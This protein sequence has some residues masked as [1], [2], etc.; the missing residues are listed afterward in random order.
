MKRTSASAWAAVSKKSGGVLC[1][2]YGHYS[3]YTEFHMA[4]ADC[5]PTYGEVRRVS[6]KVLPKAKDVK[7]IFK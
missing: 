2:L 6:I 3:I 4:K 5:P 7:G 1:D